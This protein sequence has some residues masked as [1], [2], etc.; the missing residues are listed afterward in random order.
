[1]TDVRKN[2]IDGI[3]NDIPEQEVTRGD[4][5]GEIAI[6]GWGSTFGP[7]TRAVQKVRSDGHKVSHIHVRHIWPLPKNLE[8]LLHNFKKIIVAEMNTGQLITIL[9]SQYLINAQGLNKISGQPFKVSE[10]EEAILDSLE[11]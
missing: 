7:I 3:K 8:A 4:T 9:R 2:K 1:M 6:V 5:A 11:N 10:I